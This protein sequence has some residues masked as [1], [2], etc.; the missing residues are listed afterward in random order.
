MEA[1]DP[2][3]SELPDSATLSRF[4]FTDRHYRVLPSPR[5]RPEAFTPPPDG[6]LSVFMTTGLDEYTI[7]VIG[8]DVG[9]ARGKS[10]HGRADITAMVCREAR[11]SLDVDNDPPRHTNVTGWP[12][13]KADIKATTQILAQMAQLYL[14]AARTA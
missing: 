5:V 1:L 7:V 13:D 2:A 14:V 11:L 4:L 9:A 8:R 10:L 6:R 3:P 12:P